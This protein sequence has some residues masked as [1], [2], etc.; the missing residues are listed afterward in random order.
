MRCPVASFTKKILNHAM[1]C[2]M[3]QDFRRKAY[4]EKR[5]ALFSQSEALTTFF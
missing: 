3:V 4:K 5:P 2:L 1:S